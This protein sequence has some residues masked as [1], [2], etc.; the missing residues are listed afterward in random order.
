MNIPK[1]ADSAN[2]ALT[3]IRLCCLIFD[4]DAAGVIISLNV[5]ADKQP[6]SFLCCDKEDKFCLFPVIGDNLRAV[7][8]RYLC[9]AK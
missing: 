9:V 4:S 6:L 8:G 3:H 2:T 7:L 5:Y 1:N